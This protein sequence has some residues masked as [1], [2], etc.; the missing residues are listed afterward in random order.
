MCLSAERDRAAVKQRLQLRQA[1]FCGGED[2]LIALQYR[3]LSLEAC[4][5]N[6]KGKRHEAPQKGAIVLE[7]FFILLIT[8]QR[9]L[10][11]L[12]GSQAVFGRN[13][14]GRFQ[15]VDACVRVAVEVVHYPVFMLAGTARP[16]GR[17]IVNMGPV[18]DA[19]CRNCQR[20]RGVA[21]A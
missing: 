3:L 5:G 2:A 1:R 9:E 15:H 17:R 20:N 4:I 16:M 21:L 8:H 14:L 13:I 12:R 18:R 10:V 19:V 7:R 6:T 11:L